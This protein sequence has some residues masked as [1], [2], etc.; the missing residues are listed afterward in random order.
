MLK[1][2]SGDWGGDATGAFV[3]ETIPQDYLLFDGTIREPQIELPNGLIIDNVDELE[4]DEA[5][6]FA[7]GTMYVGVRHTGDNLNEYVPVRVTDIDGDLIRLTPDLD[8]KKA[9]NPFGITIGKLPG[10]ETRKIA[11]GETS[12]L[13]MARPRIDISHILENIR[14]S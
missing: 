6:L 1:R 9:D 14:E 3:V 10:L 4:I 2:G 5:Q 11:R 12:E 13:V 7:A 8:Y